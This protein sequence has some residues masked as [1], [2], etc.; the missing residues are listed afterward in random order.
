MRVH[1][2]LRY[3]AFR[4]RVV[5]EVTPEESRAVRIQI[6]TASGE[7]LSLPDVWTAALDIAARAAIA[8]ALQNAL[9]AD[10][11]RMPTVEPL[12]MNDAA[13]MQ[14]LEYMRRQA[15]RQYAAAL[16]TGIDAG[17]VANEAAIAAGEVMN[18]AAIAAGDMMNEIAAIDR[19]LSALLARGQR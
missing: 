19:A 13:A 8:A 14:V 12:D 18:E 7:Y 5:G 9:G 1:A 6:E 15:E 17:A 10:L 16:K 3:G 2:N 4:Y 11:K